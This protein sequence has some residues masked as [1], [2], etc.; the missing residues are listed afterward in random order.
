MKTKN[1]QLDGNFHSHL[2]KGEIHLLYK[3]LI[4]LLL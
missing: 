1:I 3:Y 2:L 4:N